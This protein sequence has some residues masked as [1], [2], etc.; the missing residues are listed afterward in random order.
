MMSKR[1]FIPTT[2]TYINEKILYISDAILLL[3]G[4]IAV[5]NEA[6]SLTLSLAIIILKFVK[7]YYQWGCDGLH[8]G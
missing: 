8:T 3:S 7:V 6:F 4:A 2:E 5:R 1:V